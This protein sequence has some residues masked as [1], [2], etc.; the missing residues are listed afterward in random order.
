MHSPLL[1]ALAI[2]FLLPAC[3]DKGGVTTEKQADGSLKSVATPTYGAPLKPMEADLDRDGI[4]L[5]DIIVQSV[6]HPQGDERAAMHVQ[7]VA[8]NSGSLSAWGLEM[9]LS[10]RNPEGQTLGGHSTYVHFDQAL[11]PGQQTTFTVRAP[12]FRAALEEVDVQSDITILKVIRTEPAKPIA[13]QA[14]PINPAQPEDAPSAADARDITVVGA[15]QHDASS[16]QMESK[17]GATTKA[18]EGPGP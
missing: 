18:Q 16:A 12:L 1:L 4:A 7:A 11:L 8:E 6:A 9:Y 13:R 17:N 14:R 15:G 3:R 5:S 10:F 2:A